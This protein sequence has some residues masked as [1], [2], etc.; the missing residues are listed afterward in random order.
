MVRTVEIRFGQWLD[1]VNDAERAELTALPDGACEDAFYCDLA[2]GTGGLRGKLGLGPNRMNVYTVGKATQ[3]LADYLNA[4]FENP[5]VALCRDTRHGSEE[6]V[7]RVAEVLAGNGIKSF[8]YERVE[9]TPALSFAV[10]ELE[11]SAGVNITASHN[12]AAY[13]GYKVYGADG[14]QI[15]V[16]AAKA[17]QAAIDSVDYFDDVKATPFDE[18]LTEGQVQWTPERVLDRYV[19]ETLKCSTGVDCSD[20]KIVYTPLHGVGLECVSRVLD[21]IHVAEVT[22]VAEQ[23]VPD[24]DFPT[25][26]YP[27]PEIREALE[28]GLKYCDEVKP[29]LLLA[30]D[31]D[32]DRVGIAVPHGGEYKLLSGNEVGLLLMD[33]LAGKAVEAGES[34]SHKVVCTT[35]VSAPMADDL[36]FDRGFELR[37]TLTGFKFIGEQVGLLEQHG[38]ESDF[39]MGF[40]ESYGYLA[41]TSVRDKDAVVATMLVCELASYWKARNKG[42]H[43]VME[44]LYER[45]GYWRSAQLSQIYEGPK[46]DADMAAIMAGLRA[47]TP[48]EVAGID[49]S[50]VIDY[51][52]GAVMPAVNPSDSQTLPTAN[53]VELR[54]SDGSRLLFRPSGTESKAKA[55]VFAKGEDCAEAEE[56]LAALNDFAKR[57]LEGENR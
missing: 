19:E 8:L 14:C 54:L 25:C 28:L 18:A 7:R 40:E 53:V 55:Y 43:E 42:L 5:A 15:T 6:F 51:A 27:N 32:T 38:R 37:R 12:P 9:P 52:G 36:A 46:G 29:D 34:L 1:H 2:F 56:K 33:F 30:T 44:A 49:I 22:T 47:D 23:C 35:I 10:R 11:C 50:Q 3:G 57:I 20:L 21:A 13:N 16:D 41:G 31:P 17:I 4:S 24:G 39:L 26:P 48:A 45:Y